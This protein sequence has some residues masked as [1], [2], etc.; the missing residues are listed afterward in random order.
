M[1][2]I[3]GIYDLNRANRVNAEVLKKMTE[4]INHR[5][6]DDSAYLIRENLGFGF[7]RLSIID[8]E[9]GKQPFYNKDQSVILIC[10]G[11]IYNYKELRNELINKGYKFST[12]CDVEVIVHLYD[13]YGIDF[14]S[15]LN[16]Q[17]AFALYDTRCRALFL[18]RDHFGICPLFYTKVDDLLLFG[19]EIKAILKH[20]LVKR[21][22]NTTALDQLFCFPGVVS[23]TTFF[24][25][26]I[27][28]KPGHYLK[29]QNNEISIHE[30]WDLMYPLESEEIEQK[31]ESYYVDRLEELLLQSVRYRLNSDVPVGFYLSGGLDSSLVGALMKKV[32][33]DFRYKSFSIGYPSAED[34]IHDERKYQQLMAKDL[35]SLH[36]VI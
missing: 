10:N 1:C 4:T 20:P 15:R 3:T 23:P 25:N 12:Q 31:P 7:K 21:K 24:E 11:E 36:T 17:F 33:P 19:S 27:S 29:V 9:H 28:L 35:N 26:I 22:V 32:N 5:G 8:L 30:Y 18:V 34:M 16:G 13:E 2:G 6:P 14:V